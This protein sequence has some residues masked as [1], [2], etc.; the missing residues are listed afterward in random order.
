MDVEKTPKVFY[1]VIFE[2]N[3]LSFLYPDGIDHYL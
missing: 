3:L 2:W 1:L